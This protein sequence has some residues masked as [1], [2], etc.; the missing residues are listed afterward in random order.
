MIATETTS[1]RPTSRRH[2]RP[3]RTR[4]VGALVVPLAR[5]LPWWHVVGAAVAA[6]GLVVHGLATAR[7]LDL[8]GATS[9]LRRAA[10]VLGVGV[11]FVFDDP[12]ESWSSGTPV[13]IA[14]RRAVRCV[15]VLVPVV[16]TW[17]VVLVGA[18]AAV[19]D[20]V[21]AS[22][23]GGWMLPSVALSVQAAGLA[24][25]VLGVAAVASRWSTDRSGGIAAITAVLAVLP[26][27][28]IL[29]GD[30]AMWLP[31]TVA[32][33]AWEGMHVRWA[34]V[35]AL[36]LAAAAA[37]ARDP[38]RAQLSLRRFRPA[39]HDRVRSTEGDTP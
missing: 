34:V 39:G 30:W 12:T 1:P 36:G 7:E 5:A 21:P 18:E 23:E 14:A 4:T 33:D 16:V 15:L 31:P 10:V 24:G 20:V 27:A 19:R 6:G 37:G 2:P 3:S 22:S 13:S 25:L 28:V 11:A 26:I 8:V 17:A 32:T 35:A 9:T 38:G 29:S